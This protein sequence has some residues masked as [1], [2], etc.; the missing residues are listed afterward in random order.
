MH[1]PATD[2]GLKR[3]VFAACQS[4]SRLEDHRAGDPRALRQKLRAGRKVHCDFLI[5]KLSFI[6][7]LTTQESTSEARPCSPLVTLTYPKQPPAAL[8]NVSLKFSEQYEP[9]LILAP[10]VLQ[11]LIC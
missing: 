9:R 5:V 1:T 7:Y 6:L 4:C 2:N 8:K 11:P 10:T 3:F